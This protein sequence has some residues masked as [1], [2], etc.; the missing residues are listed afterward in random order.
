MMA[1]EGQ[2]AVDATVER[3]RRIEAQQ[4]KMFMRRVRFGE[5]KYVMDVWPRRQGKSYTLK[6]L[7]KPLFKTRQKS[8]QLLSYS[9]LRRQIKVIRKDTQ[10]VLVDDA[11]Q[12]LVDLIKVKR[13]DV[14]VIGLVSPEMEGDAVENPETIHKAVNNVVFE[15]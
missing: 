11:S 13:P 2:E 8:A 9:K 6:N 12:A 15:K 7:V 4:Q 5:E 1:Q 14:R 10:V 3:T